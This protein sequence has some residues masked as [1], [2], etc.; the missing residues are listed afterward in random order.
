MLARADYHL[1]QTIEV[2]TFVNKVL[3]TLVLDSLALFV[4][5]VCQSLDF[6]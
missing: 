4:M 2:F 6:C 3:D 5:D 1:V